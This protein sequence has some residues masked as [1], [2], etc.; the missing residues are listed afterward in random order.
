M[1]SVRPKS[2][3]NDVKNINLIDNKANIKGTC[4]KD[5]INILARA[6]VRVRVRARVCMC[7]RLLCCV[8]CFDEHRSTFYCGSDFLADYW[9]RGVWLRDGK[10][11]IR[12]LD[13]HWQIGAAEGAF[14]LHRKTLGPHARETNS[15]PYRVCFFF[16]FSPEQNDSALQWRCSKLGLCEAQT[17]LSDQPTNLNAFSFRLLHNS[18][19]NAFSFRLLLNS[20]LNAIYKWRFWCCHFVSRFGLAVRR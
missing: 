13:N 14:S 6:Y 17:G 8:R 1:T 16:L 15:P 10:N 2:Y 5:D 19:L 7:A 12:L 4:N 3:I 9:G 11:F 20:S 18:S